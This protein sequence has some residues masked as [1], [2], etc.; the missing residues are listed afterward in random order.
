[1][2]EN[3]SL[4]GK[5]AVITGATSGI[6]FQSL[7]ALAQEDAFVIGVGRDR[8]RCATA[9]SQVKSTYP[10]AR[11]AYL[12]AD[13][14]QQRQVRRLASD[15]HTVIEHTEKGAL[16]I[17]VNNAG[18]YSEKRVLTE[19]G[20]ELT[21]AVN[22]LA[23]FLL[24]HELLPLMQ[25]SPMARIITVSSASHYN[26][27]INIK[28]AS[29]PFPYLG[30]WAYKVSKLANIL[31]TC[32]LNRRLSGTTVHA[33]AVDPGLVNTAIAQ[34]GT[35]KLSAWVWKHR[36][37]A[38]VPPDVPAKTILYLSREETIQHNPECFWRDSH[39][40][41]PSRLARRADIARMLWEES[42]RL[43]QITQ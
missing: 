28:K 30:L 29:K 37:E 2:H 1:M 20:I 17:L 6:G 39:P 32:E 10:N 42:E 22:H 25:R 11:V 19:D 8:G 4:A 34:K 12:V 23:P 41:T 40:K 3:M 5:I 21:F 14:S 43:C 9:E 35:G 31:F 27:W 26:T 24:T 16:D 18:T 13:L 38:G 33:F 15:I 36:R 7:L